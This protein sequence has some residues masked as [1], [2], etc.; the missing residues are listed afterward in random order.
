MCLCVCLVCKKCRRLNKKRL[1]FCFFPLEPRLSVF[2]SSCKAK[3]RQ[4][5]SVETRNMLPLPTTTTTTHHHHYHHHHRD[6]HHLGEEGQHQQST[7]DSEEMAFMA[8]QL[9]DGNTLTLFFLLDFLLSRIFYKW[10][11]YLTSLSLFL[12]YLLLLSQRRHIRRRAEHERIRGH[13][14]GIARVFTV[15]SYRERL[16]YCRGGVGDQQTTATPTTTQKRT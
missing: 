6:H 1:I 11:E 12:L 14:Q 7:L 2:L 8:S 10:I 5:I 15:D 16:A 13:A 4:K 9:L 3:K